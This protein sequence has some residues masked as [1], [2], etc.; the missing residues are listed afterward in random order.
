M[1]SHREGPVQRSVAGGSIV[2]AIFLLA[3]ALIASSCSAP[4]GS[5]SEP[6]ITPTGW[7]TPVS[8]PQ[9]NSNQAMARAN[10][11]GTGVYTTRGVRQLTDLKWKFK[12][13]GYGVNTIPVIQGSIAYFGGGDGRLYAVDAETGVEKWNRRLDTISTSAPAIADHTVYVGAWEELY[14]LS[15]DT[16]EV[17]WKF[18][19]ERGSDDSYYADPVVYGGT[20]YFGGRHNLYALDSHNG[21]EKW[22]LKLSGVTAS[23]PTVYDGMLYI[24]SYS[25]D[26]RVDTYLY[27]L[28]SQTGQEIWKRKVRG[29]GI[30][31]A[32]AVADGVLYV[33]TTDDGLLALDATN[34]QEKWRY[35]P[36]SGVT[37]GPAVAY[38]LVYITDRGRLYAVDAQTGKEK[39]AH[40]GGGILYSDPVIAE[41]VVYYTTSEPGSDSSMADVK[42]KGYLHAVDAQSGHELWKFNVAGI[43]SRAPAVADGIVFFGSEEDYLYAVK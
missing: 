41:G 6:A 34:G 11:H 8:A 24:G 25:P 5:S 2:V 36:G 16:G 3:V 30:R 28:D 26:G 31:G 18:E 9:P 23:V 42:P 37:T 13:V 32:I 38:D 33:G 15:T 12:P 21:K 39:W 35:Y 27:A 20:I 43:T 17:R 7:D 19:P 1:R 40:E 14:A 22:K 10:V 4:I 29:D